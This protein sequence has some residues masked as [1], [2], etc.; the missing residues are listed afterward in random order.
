MILTNIMI[1]VKLIV[2]M[3]MVMIS[4]MVSIGIY[5]DDKDTNE[6]FD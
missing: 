5:N 3:G 6:E 2:M 4:T 1:V